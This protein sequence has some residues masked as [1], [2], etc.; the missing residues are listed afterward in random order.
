[1]KRICNT[2]ISAEAATFGLTITSSEEQLLNSFEKSHRAIIFAW[3]IVRIEERKKQFQR[4]P[5]TKEMKRV[6]EKKY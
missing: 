2:S 5:K 3:E 1:M 6:K 4:A